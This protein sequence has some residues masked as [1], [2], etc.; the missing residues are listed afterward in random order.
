MSLDIR[1]RSSSSPDD[2]GLTLSF[3]DDGYYWFLHPLF[4][5]L[6]AESGKYIDLY[7]DARFTRDDC[8]RLHALLTEAELMARHQPQTWEVRVG[9]R[10]EP[11][12]KNLY[13]T[14][15]RAELLKLIA[16]FRAMIDAIE[17]LGGHLE[18]IG[19]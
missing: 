15:N 7:G 16:T 17:K 8:P 18:C 10:I 2:E 9:T 4:E 6:R 12:R 14:V 1:V 11:I 5:R 3:D 19:D 13:R